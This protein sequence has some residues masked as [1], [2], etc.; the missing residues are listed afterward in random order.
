MLIFY[1]CYSAEP[2]A[3]KRERRWR[4]TFRRPV[5]NQVNEFNAQAKEVK[6][7]K[8]VCPMSV[9]Y[10]MNVEKKKK[11]RNKAR[12]ESAIHCELKTVFGCTRYYR[13]DL[14]S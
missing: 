4:K 10:E 13:R 2:G 5:H 14:Y 6:E 7:E 9:S 1:V 8:E 11:R 12:L 3:K